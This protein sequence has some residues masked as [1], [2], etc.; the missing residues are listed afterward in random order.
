MNGSNKALSLF[1][2]QLGI[3]SE[4]TL[5]ILHGLL[6]TSD[7]WQ[8]LGKEFAATHRV[9]LIDQR[10]HGKSPHDPIHHYPAMA[11][12]LAL[13][14]EEH[15]IER[16]T[17]LGHSMGG[18]TALTF[19]HDHPELIEGLVIADMSARAYAPHHGP[20]FDALLDAPMPSAD[21]RSAIESFLMHRLNDPGMVAFLMKNVRREKT[22]GYTWRPNVPVLAAAMAEVVGEVPLETNT[23]PTLVIYGGQSDYVN[24]SDLA[25]FD[26]RCMQLETHCIEGA[27]H[28]LHA[29]HPEEFYSTVSDFLAR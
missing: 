4:K 18:K 2:R 16:A 11:S 29:S 13:Y 5:I 19:A 22:G 3:E 1:S 26:A 23:L 21:S 27:G 17:L 14:F 9:H 28:W 8:S 25:Y 6:G 12:D 7:N 15:G 10:N 20:I 24:E